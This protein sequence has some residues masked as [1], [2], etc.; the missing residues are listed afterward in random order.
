LQLDG[1]H[2]HLQDHNICMHAPT[3]Y[4]QLS[5]R[6]FRAK[7]HFH[8]LILFQLFSA[9]DTCEISTNS[10]QNYDAGPI[11]RVRVRINTGHF[12]MATDGLVGWD[13]SVKFTT[14]MTFHFFPEKNYM[15]RL[16]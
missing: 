15:S 7:T 5:E 11:C 6:T 10:V 9:M 14:V 1:S 2:S 12:F 8:T 16:G 4:E 13:A 3:N